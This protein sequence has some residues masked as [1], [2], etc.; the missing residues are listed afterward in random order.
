MAA[1]RKA[2]DASLKLILN[3]PQLFVEFLRDF[4]KIEILRDI[5]PADAGRPPLE[6]NC[7]AGE[8]WT[9]D[10]FNEPLEDFEECVQRYIHWLVSLCVSDWAYEHQVAGTIKV[11]VADNKSRPEAGLLVTHHRVEVGQDY[12]ALLW[13]NHTLLPLRQPKDCQATIYLRLL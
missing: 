2:R 9:T 12:I 1:I 8:V 11:F 5:E 7:M 10:D 13:F 4:I 6:F 3:E